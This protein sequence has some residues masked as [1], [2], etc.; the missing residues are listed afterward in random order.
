MNDQQGCEPPGISHDERAASPCRAG[1]GAPLDS[2]ELSIEHAY[3]R[4]ARQS[5]EDI[6]EFAR[7]ASDLV[8]RG[9]EAYESDRIL[10]L[11]AEAI[12]SRIGVA[13]GRLPPE[14]VRDHPHIPFRLAKDMRNFVS[15]E[16]DRVDPDVVWVA[17][18]SQIPAF[19][20]QI[21][22]ILRG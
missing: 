17:M 18:E 19:A 15:H 4:R 11:A 9:K 2:R 12:S 10:Q 21:S 22:Q 5:L 1:V 7:D 16:Y 8:S 20:E 3:G 13:A 14:L 6:L